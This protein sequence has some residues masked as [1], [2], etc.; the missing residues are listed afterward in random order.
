MQYVRMRRGEAI[1]G[2]NVTVC[3][4]YVRCGGEGVES[5]M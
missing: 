4:Q 5:N 1:C 2:G 3:V